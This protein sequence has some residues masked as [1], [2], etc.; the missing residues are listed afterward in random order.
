MQP[1]DLTQVIYDR[2]CLRSGEDW[3]RRNL[4]PVA[5]V[6]VALAVL[7]VYKDKKKEYA[8]LYSSKLLSMSL[9]GCVNLYIMFRC[10]FS[11]ISLFSSIFYVLHAFLCFM[12]TER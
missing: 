3:V 9:T 8:L 1:G 11:F 10:P 6:A 2:G 5:A 12:F 4:V 7:Q